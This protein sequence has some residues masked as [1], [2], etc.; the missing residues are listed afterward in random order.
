MLSERERIRG[1]PIPK[2]KY[3][4]FVSWI[5]GDKNNSEK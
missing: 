2:N 4:P 5:F 1:A 3:N